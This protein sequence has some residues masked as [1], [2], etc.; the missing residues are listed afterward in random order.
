MI[1]LIWYFSGKLLSKGL[2]LSFIEYYREYLKELTKI[3][4]KDKGA[5]ISTDGLYRY[6]LWRVWD[7]SKPSVLFICLNPSTADATDDDP[8]IRR[9]IGFAKSWGF[10]SLYMGNLFA[11]RATNPNE[12]F[13]AR[14]PVGANNDKWLLELSLKCQ[15]VVFAWGAN[16]N[17]LGRNK[18]V[19]LTFP[20]A[21]CIKRTKEGH[22]S[23]PLYLKADITLINY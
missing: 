20:E 2:C 11:F 10:G 18:T 5:D 4:I 3:Y 7:K 22:P 14:D 13:E 17:L 23:H 1:R 21:Y 15:K 16:G 9:C 8:T 12:L 19:A 6:S